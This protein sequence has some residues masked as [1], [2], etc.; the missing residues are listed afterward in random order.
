M[1]K[2]VLLTGWVLT[3]LAILSV[4]T[5][6]VCSGL[7]RHNIVQTKIPTKT[8]NGKTPDAP[9]CGNGDIGL[10]LGGK[11]D[12]FRFCIG[13]N[14][15]WRAYPVYPENGIYLPGGLDIEIPSLE[16]ADYHTETSLDE[17]IIRGSFKNTAQKLDISAWVAAE[18]N[19]IIIELTA[20]RDCVAK[21]RLW[22]PEDEDSRLESGHIEN[23]SWVARSFLEKPLLEWTTH[24]ALGMK[25]LGNEIGENGEIRLLNDRKTTVIIRV[26]TNFDNEKWKETTIRETLDSNIPEIEEMWDAH[27][28]SWKRYWEKSHIA[29]PDPFLEKYYYV[30]QFLLGCTMNGDKFAPG[31]WGVFVTKDRTSWG[32]DYHLNYNYQAPFWACYSSN[33]IE[34][35]DC[36]DRPL[37]DYMDRGREHAKKLLGCRGIYYP[38][39]IGPRG[40]CT[41]MWPLTPEAMEQRYG[42]RDNTIDDG[43]K[44]LGQKINAVFSVGNMLMRFYSTYDDDYAKK[45]YPYMLA[46]AD[47]WEDYL[48]FEDGRYVIKMDHYGEVMPNLHN[49]G[50]WEHLLGDVNSTLS[51]GLVRMLFKGMIDV[52]EHLD[53]DVNRHEKWNHIL[54]HL[55]DYTITEIDGRKTLKNVEQG[56]GWSG[57]ST[58]LARVSIHGMILPGG[59]CGPISTP[60][61][62]RVLLSDIDHWKDRA[63]NPGEWGNSYNNGIETVFPGAVRVGYDPDYI[64]DRLKERIEAGSYPNGCITAGGGGLETLS[65][66]PMTINEM[67]LQSYEHVIRVFPVWNRKK[68][69]SFQN[70]R[71]YGAFLVSSE[72]KNEQIAFVRIESERG[73]KCRIENPWNDRE[74][75]IFRYGKDNGVLSGE[76]LEFETGKGEIVELR[77]K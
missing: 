17:A 48:E 11:P 47:F 60:E 45:I 72:L 40:L 30:S 27:L 20:D 15:F 41:T 63:T 29:I 39:G 8:P 49:E 6:A 7:S 3:V 44:F 13:K 75:S 51:L 52:S 35:T 53:L 54:E 10:V 67:L 62:N 42:T 37:L 55:S 66:V 24:V 74:V 18:H 2:T 19:A 22:S 65:A 4:G 5:T 50:K 31:I 25:V 69:A 33:R 77:E 46:C 38:V 16:G 26:N 12:K 76:F 34:M 1:N 23:G 28:A 64:I 68:D 73:R 61:L 71:A 21:I 9:L 43:Y 36:F 56:N 70:L 14:D 59:V 57:R 58:G 32:G